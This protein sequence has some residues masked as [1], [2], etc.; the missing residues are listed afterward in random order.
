MKSTPNAPQLIH[1]ITLAATSLGLSLVSLNS[2]CTKNNPP[3]I[4]IPKPVASKPTTHPLIIEVR[5]FKS[6]QG[7]CRIALYHGKDGFNQPEQAT[8]KSTEPI[9]TANANPT[10]V[11]WHI[12]QSTLEN[13]LGD[14]RTTHSKLKLA[15]SAHHDKNT[16]D[17][18]D[19]NPLGIPNEPYGFSQ[20]P[21]RGFGPPSFDEVFF[22]YPTE[23][24][25][26]SAD[27]SQHIIIDIR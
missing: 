19:K 17:K 27:S 16:N 4:P 3:P 21:K 20:N 2:G 5:G 11:L 23:Q 12:D 1:A 26:D 18:L 15:A 24:S 22:E 7:Q 9:P 8:L 13:A 10:S 25:T 6:S 14:Q